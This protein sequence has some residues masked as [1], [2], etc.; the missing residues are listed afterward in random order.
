M[1]ITHLL[2]K[3][4]LNMKR[5]E[6]RELLKL[7]T[8]PELISFAGGLPDPALFP[9]EKIKEISQEVYD[10]DA[11]NAL[12]YGTSEGDLLLREML[13]QRYRKLGFKIDMD[14]IIIVSGSQQALDLTGKLFVN[15]GDRIVCEAPSYLGSLGAFLSY[16]AEIEDIPLDDEGIDIDALKTRYFKLKDN[17]EMIKFLYMIPDFQNPSGI[18]MSLKR[19]QQIMEFSEQENILII[20]DS[21]YREFNFDEAYH[22]SFFEMSQTENVVHLGTFSKIFMPGLRIGWIIA[23]HHINDRYVIGRQN[24]DLCTSP[25]TQ[26]IA[27]R[28]MQK[29]FLDE[30]LE[31][32]KREYK[33]K[34]DEMLKDFGAYFPEEISWNKP[35]GGLFLFIQFP[36]YIDSR[37][38][39]K[40]AIERNVAFV[41]GTPFF[42][43]GKG[44]SFARINFS[45]SS[46]EK[47]REGVRR[48]GELI[49]EEIKNRKHCN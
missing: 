36:D 23:P 28:F 15:P 40:K 19:R 48:L 3:Q 8:N 49:K 47:N 6:I 11:I 39:L 14:H 34:R 25:L 30:Y 27:A 9:V 43:K 2:S 16:G 41:P 45:Y 33:I 5:S 18:H 12:Q 26:K 20:E 17:G 4:H 29:G 35:N 44:K 24:T 42:V 10:E 13:L 38:L 31:N 22:P 32:V 21:P 37:E 1:E 46:I 7:T